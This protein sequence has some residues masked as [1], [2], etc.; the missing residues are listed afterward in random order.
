MSWVRAS[1]EGLRYCTKGASSQPIESPNDRQKELRIEKGSEL[2]KPSKMKWKKSQ[3]APLPDSEA[4]T[5]S[6][7]KTQSPFNAQPA[8]K[9]IRKRDRRQKKQPKQEATVQ[10]APP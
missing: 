2:I 9:K 4:R 8:K 1:K 5:P 10:T 3:A 7:D 6:P